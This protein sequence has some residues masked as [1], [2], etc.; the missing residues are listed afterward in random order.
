[1]DTS[2]TKGNVVATTSTE[3]VVFIAT[4]PLIPYL[5]LSCGADSTEVI[6]APAADLKE[7]K[8]HARRS[9][10]NTCPPPPRAV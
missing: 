7:R 1:V 6:G 10:R 8:A 2:S 9:P 4:T 5:L 3:V